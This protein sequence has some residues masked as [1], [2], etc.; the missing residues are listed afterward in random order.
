MSDL[1]WIVDPGHGWLRVDLRAYPD[2][3]DY[4]T[5]FGYEDIK[6]SHCVFLEEDCEAPAFLAAH[7]EIDWK[8]VPSTV[9]DDDWW[10]RSLL[11]RIPKRMAA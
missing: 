10:G 3:L 6:A 9:M 11:G 2:A 4:G 1:H 8:R 7:P 5:G